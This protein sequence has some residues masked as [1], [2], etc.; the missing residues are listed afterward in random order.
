MEGI[1]IYNPLVAEDRRIINAIAEA[2]EM[3]T[4]LPSFKLYD[5]GE[6]SVAK[7]ICEGLKEKI[8]L[9]NFPL[10]YLCSRE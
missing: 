10:C 2:Q 1:E 4:A 9:Q 7:L 3:C 6:A 5:A 8:D